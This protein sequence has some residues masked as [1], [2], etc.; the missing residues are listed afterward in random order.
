[1]DPQTDVFVLA[2]F[3]LAVLVLAVLDLAVFVLAVFVLAV[4]SP[5]GGAKV[6]ASPNGGATVSECKSQV[7]YSPKRLGREGFLLGK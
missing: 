1:M 4:S 7:P 5:N 6:E 3:V 2:V